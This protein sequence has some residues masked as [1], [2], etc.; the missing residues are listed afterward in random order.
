MF[1]KLVNLCQ[2][3]LTEIPRTWPW[4][5]LKSLPS[6]RLK[7]DVLKSRSDWRPACYV[8]VPADRWIR[9]WQPP[10]LFIKSSVFNKQE[11]YTQA[12]K[13]ETVGFIEVN[14]REILF[15]CC[16]FEYF[17]YEVVKRPS[18]AITKNKKTRYCFS[19]WTCFC[20]L[21][22]WMKKC[23]PAVL[24][25]FCVIMYLM[26]LAR[27]P[28]SYNLREVNTSAAHYL[29]LGYQIMPFS[30]ECSNFANTYVSAV[31]EQITF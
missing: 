3:R 1:Q 22:S 24:A 9:C 14:C 4:M 25:V 5:N 18:M 16:L 28:P 31:Q 12:Q 20:S 7:M 30:I 10:Q 8:S 29:E 11:A 6:L 15:F 27:S 2:W 23:I 17:S 19:L 26:L 13:I 21:N